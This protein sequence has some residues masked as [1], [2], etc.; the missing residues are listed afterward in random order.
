MGWLFPYH[1]YSR[2]TLINERIEGWEH[3]GNKAVVLKHCM[4]GNNL[5]KLIEL[6]YSTGDKIRFIALDMLRKSDGVWGYKDLDESCGPYYYNC[7]LG[8]IEQCTPAKS[9][10]AIKWREQVKEYWKTKRQRA[11]ERRQRLA[12][13]I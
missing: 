9:E 13:I 7:P 10:F 8:Y 3:N 5:W 2:R 12:A 4:K 6:T 1:T 11:A